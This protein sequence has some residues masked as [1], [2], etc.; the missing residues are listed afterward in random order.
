MFGD[1]EGRQINTSF[2]C[3]RTADYFLVGELKQIF[4]EKGR[5]VVPIYFWA[6]RE[7]N[8][9]ARQCFTG[10]DVQ[11]VAVFGRRPKLSHPGHQNIEFKINGELFSYANELA[12][13]GIVTLA[14][15]PLVSD[16][17]DFANSPLIHFVQLKASTE[18]VDEYISIDLSASEQP[19]SKTSQAL[20]DPLDDA[21]ILSLVDQSPSFDWPA[22][23]QIIRDA[24]RSRSQQSKFYSRFASMFGAYKP[25]YVLC[26]NDH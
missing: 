23:I 25:L 18:P 9:I 24:N 10:V 17:Q 7:G 22:L 5:S 14:G 26:L 6:T 12:Q 19:F 20:T 1:E 4:A 3:E 2:F 15:L 11:T 16:L 21:D 8:S 13:R